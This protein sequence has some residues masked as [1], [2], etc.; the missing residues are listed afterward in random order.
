M[1]ARLW[2]G[3]AAIYGFLAV[4]LGAFGAHALKARLAPDLMTVYRTG[5]EYHFYHA[6]ALLAVG[7]YA[8]QYPGRMLDIAGICFAA[9]IL[10]FSGSLY[11]LALSGIKVLGAITPFGGLLLLAGWLALAW[12]AWRA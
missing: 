11:A 10:L 4:A 2:V 6:L 8:T 12:S 7:V 3:V 9:G 5:V 1:N